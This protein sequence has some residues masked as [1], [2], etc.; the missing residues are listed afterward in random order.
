MSL[1]HENLRGPVYERLFGVLVQRS[2]Y[3]RGFAGWE[4]S[5]VDMDSFERYRQYA[6]AELLSQCASIPGNPTWVIAGLG[7]LVHS[8]Y[9]H[10]WTRPQPG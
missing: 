3:P 2:S 7:E 5:E 8:N 6:A 9:Y 1:R 10:I 4:T